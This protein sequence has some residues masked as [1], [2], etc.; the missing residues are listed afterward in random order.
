MK[1]QY[2]IEIQFGQSN[3]HLFENHFSTENM[4]AAHIFHIIQFLKVL[5]ILPNYSLFLKIDELL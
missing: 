2:T 5:V 4:Q 1:L 3:I